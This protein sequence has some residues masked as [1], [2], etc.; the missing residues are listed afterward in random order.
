M[1]GAIPRVSLFEGKRLE[2]KQYD[3]AGSMW[4]T[5]AAVRPSFLGF[6]AGR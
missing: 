2:K 1:T 6:P 3:R 5:G 4:V